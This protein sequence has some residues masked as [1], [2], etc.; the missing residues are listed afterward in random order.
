MKKSILI[1]L[2]V[3]FSTWMVKPAL[4]IEYAT[5]FLE[6]GNPGGWTESLKTFDEELTIPSGETTD[7]D[8]WLT[9]VPEKLI[10]AGFFVDY[11]ASKVAIAESD[12]YDG[13]LPGPWDS[14]MTN[15]VGNPSGPDTFMVIVGNLGSVSPDAGRAIPIARITFECISPGEARVTFRPVPGF[16]TVVGNSSTVYDP[17]M[18]P[19]TIVISQDQDT[20]S[21]TTTSIIGECE[22]DSDCPD[23][24]LYCNGDEFCDV[25]RAACTST[26]NPCAANLVCD[27]A[28]DECK[29]SAP[30]P[31]M[32]LKHTPEA[33]Y[34]SRWM[35]LIKFLRIEGSDSH[36]DR[37]DT[38]VTFSPVSAVIMLPLVMNET[39]INCV[40]I[41]M[42][43]WWAPVDSI[44]VTVT[45]GAEEATETIE[46][47]LLPFVLEQGKYPLWEG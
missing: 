13:S 11:D 21:T 27:E 37:S 38:E 18:T 26:G 8:I 4:G 16:D 45:T 42:P 24:G 6:A 46:I 3:L 5:D 47:K 14:D 28:A 12:F 36:F 19:H 10:T 41:L 40:G 25:E 17:E 2:V 1:W 15:V 33:L 20:P 30:E 7:V 32:T 29:S 9:N 44:D 31:S 39:A 34:Q 23:D 35:P 22:A 43:R